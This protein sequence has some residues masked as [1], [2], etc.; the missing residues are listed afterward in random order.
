M[1]YV[2]WYQFIIRAEVRQNG[3]G[4]HLNT[5]RK[6]ILMKSPFITILLLIFGVSSLYAEQTPVVLTDG[7]NAITITLRNDMKHDVESFELSLDTEAAP[8]WMSA[9]PVTSSRELNQN[10]T[11]DLKLDITISGG[12][13]DET[14]S[15]PCIIHGADGFEQRF[16]ISAVISAPQGFT[17][18]LLPNTPNPFNPSTTIPFTLG[19]R[20]HVTL[21][22]YNTLGQHIT[23]LADAVY[24]AGSHSVVWNGRNAEGMRVASGIYICR[25]E[26]G[27]FVKS[28]KMLV[29]E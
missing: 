1:C 5:V 21:Q 8:Q 17:T 25:M 12:P 28:M 29:F 7:E 9:E 15:I 10:E 23:T 27:T 16:T 14:V 11:L 18:R 6:G 22:V 3:C 24:S 13:Y 26:T 2:I 20:G 4:I 19:E